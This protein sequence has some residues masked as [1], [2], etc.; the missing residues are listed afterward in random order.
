MI[1]QR[2]FLDLE[3]TRLQMAMMA[4]STLDVFDDKQRVTVIT[5]EE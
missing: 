5:K 4:Y 2:R 1:K 3:N